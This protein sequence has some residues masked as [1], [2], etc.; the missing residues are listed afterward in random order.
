MGE[1]V[2]GWVIGAR[3][4]ALRESRGWN[5]TELAAELLR[6]HGTTIPRQTAQSW[7]SGRTNPYYEAQLSLGILFDVHPCHIMYGDYLKT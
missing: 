5:Q 6:V 2:D 3:I 4:R 7:E 1:I